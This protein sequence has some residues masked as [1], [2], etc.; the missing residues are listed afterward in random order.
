MYSRLRPWLFHIDPERTH[1]A[2]LRLL[3]VAG[4]FRPLSA[5]LWKRFATQIVKSI[6]LFGLEFPNRLGL[7]A[8]YDKDGLAWRGLA[9]LGFGHVEV[10]TVVPRP[11]PGNPRPRLFRLKEDQALINRL[12]FPSRGAEFVAKRLSGS[13]PKGLVLGVNLGINKNTPLENAAEDY[14][15]LMQVFSPLADY[16]AINI[17]SPNTPGLRQLQ[18]RTYLEDLLDILARHKSKP[19]L[20]KLSPDLSESELDQAVGVITDKKLDGVIATNTTTSRQ[21]LRSLYAGE[22]GGLSGSP[23]SAR[24]RHIVARIHA[25]NGRLPIIAVGGIANGETARAALD[26]GASLVQIF[27]GLIYRGPGLVKEI[28]ETIDAPDPK[29]K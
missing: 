2:T 28:L 18:L 17:S 22:A 27:T 12:G 10:G 13:R 4:A 29:S 20:V 19:V 16:L 3:Q 7:A 11:Q 8:G 24:A 15:F 6:S 23:L 25:L 26:A 21:A 9:A 5:A 1:A 14:L